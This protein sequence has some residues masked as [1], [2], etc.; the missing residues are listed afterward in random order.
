MRSSR[1]YGC[2]KVQ[3]GGVYHFKL[4]FSAAMSALLRVIVLFSLVEIISRPACFTVIDVGAIPFAA[5]SA[6]KSLEAPRRGSN[7]S[8]FVF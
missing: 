4:T 6:A 5:D 3:E 8:V 1:V 2:I 7:R